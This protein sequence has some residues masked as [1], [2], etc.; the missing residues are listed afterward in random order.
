MNSDPIQVSIQ[1]IFYLLL[2]LL[3]ISIYCT[4]MSFTFLSF[5]DRKYRIILKDVLSLIII[6]I[7]VNIF[8]NKMPYSQLRLNLAI[9]II[10]ILYYIFIDIAEFGVNRS[11]LA[12]E[13]FIVSLVMVILLLFVLVA[14]SIFLLNIFGFIKFN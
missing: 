14:L 8:L 2:I 1:I 12:I 7:I 6:P 13:Y 10:L 3:V 4:I 9:L 5:N 11:S